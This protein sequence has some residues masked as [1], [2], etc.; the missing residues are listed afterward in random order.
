MRFHDTAAAQSFVERLV[1]RLV[2]I[3][4]GSEFVSHRAPHKGEVAGSLV[5]LSVILLSSILRLWPP[6]A[7]SFFLITNG[8]KAQSEAQE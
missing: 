2:D 1:T 7:L 8:E 5:S 4:R 3:C 6:L